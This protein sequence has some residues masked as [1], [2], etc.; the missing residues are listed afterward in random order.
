MLQVQGKHH[1]HLEADEVTHVAGLDVVWV[2]LLDVLVQLQDAA[3]RQGHH[4]LLLKQGV[5]VSLPCSSSMQQV[6]LYL[7]Q[8][9]VSGQSDM[10]HNYVCLKVCNI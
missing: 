6:K 1:T 8:G 3:H 5:S 2:H 10:L 9:S 7:C 4:A